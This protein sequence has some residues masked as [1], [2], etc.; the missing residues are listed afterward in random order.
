MRLPYWKRLSVIESTIIFNNLSYSCV[1]NISIA[2]PILWLRRTHWSRSFSFCLVPAQPWPPTA[3]M[4]FFYP[5]WNRRRGREADEKYRTWPR[6]IYTARWRRN[7]SKIY[8]LAI[9]VPLHKLY[10]TGWAFPSI[11]SYTHPWA[12]LHRRSDSVKPVKRPEKP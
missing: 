7:R 4:A 9:S 5:G 10:I 2:K 12:F 3:S 8:V 1:Q 11:R 6:R